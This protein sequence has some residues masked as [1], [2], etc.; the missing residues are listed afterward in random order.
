MLRRTFLTGIAATA[1]SARNCALAVE[2]EMYWPGR[3]WD[4]VVPADVG[5][6]ADQLA[7]ADAQITA[8]YPDIT[9][10]VV[11]RGGAYRLRAV[12]RLRVRSG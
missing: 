8:A 4:V 11:V 3:G 5:M 9:G 7:I 10:T 1:L 6:S 2:P 12:L